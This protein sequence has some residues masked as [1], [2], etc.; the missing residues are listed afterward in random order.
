MISGIPCPYQSKNIHFLKT[1]VQID[2]VTLIL[3]LYPVSN[4]IYLMVTVIYLCQV[5]IDTVYHQIILFCQ[6]F[7]WP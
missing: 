1:C 5:M 6:I 4:P 3:S 2:R 7:T